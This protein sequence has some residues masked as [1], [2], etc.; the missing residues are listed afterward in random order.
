GGEDSELRTLD[1]ETDLLH[2][3]VRDTG[4]GIPPEKQQHIFASFSQADASTTRQYGGTGLG[5]AICKKIVELMGG[6]IWV[7]STVG[8]GSIFHFTVS[9]GR[10]PAH[11]QLAPI[12]SPSRELAG[13]R[14]LIVE[15]NAINRRILSEIVS[16]W[17]MQPTVAASATEALALM[18]SA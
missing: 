12:P 7:E 14:V 18:R 2:F 1:S 9:L 8:Q 17:R 11:G 4:I 6:T 13:L 16:S 15:D 5:L 10:G 3:T